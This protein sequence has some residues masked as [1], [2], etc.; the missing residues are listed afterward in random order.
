[1]QIIVEMETIFFTFFGAS[2]IA[3]AHNQVRVEN[4][5][6]AMYI[7]KNIMSDKTKLRNTM[8]INV[9]PSA[10]YDI[11]TKIKESPTNNSAFCLY[12][13]YLDDIVPPTNIPT[14]GYNN[15]TIPSI[16]SN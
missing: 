8:V 11:V 10:K 12:L 14:A 4:A 1:M 16:N 15:P 5:I 9:R 2:R 6:N 3:I 13:A 7:K